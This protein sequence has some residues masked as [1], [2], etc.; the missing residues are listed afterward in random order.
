[1]T[2]RVLEKEGIF[3]PDKY[4]RGQDNMR[5]QRHR[6]YFNGQFIMFSQFIFREVSSVNYLIKWLPENIPGDNSELI[7]LV[8]GDFRL[9]NVIFHPTEPRIL[10]VLDW[11]LSTIGHPFADLAHL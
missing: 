6:I 5:H 3:I 11:E 2:L 7:S 1:M 10:A 8:H 4:Q 9:D